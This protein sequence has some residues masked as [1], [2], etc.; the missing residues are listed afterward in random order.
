MTCVVA[1]R[2]GSSTRSFTNAAAIVRVVRDADFVIG[3][4][5]EKGT[6][7]ET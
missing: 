6:P 2:P 5:L 7:T 1:S 4:K 3:T